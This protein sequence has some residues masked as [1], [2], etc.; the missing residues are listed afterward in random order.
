MSSNYSWQSVETMTYEELSDEYLALEM[1]LSVVKSVL[2]PMQAARANEAIIKIL[3]A[4]NRE[5]EK[6]YPD[7]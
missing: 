3:E 2:L 5:W 1:R 4:E 6:L 7:E